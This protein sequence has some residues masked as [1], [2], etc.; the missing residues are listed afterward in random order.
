VL[1]ALLSLFPNIL[2][3]AHKPV[4]S[5]MGGGVIVTPAT[6]VS[7]MI[8]WTPTAD[9]PIHRRGVTIKVEIKRGSERLNAITRSGLWYESHE[10]REDES[11][12]QKLRRSM[13]EKR[14]KQSLITI[15]VEKTLSDISATPRSHLSQRLSNLSKAPQFAGWRHVRGGRLWALT[16]HTKPDI[17]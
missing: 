14:K 16:P 7:S 5:G 12:H 6:T 4:A 1:D 15:T 17:Q 9:A 13:L 2:Y 10:R 3:D 11:L 8:F